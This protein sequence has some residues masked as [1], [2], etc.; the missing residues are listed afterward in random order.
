[1]DESLLQFTPPP[2]ALQVDTLH[3]G[4]KSPLVG[5]EA[6]EFELKDADGRILTGASLKGSVVLLQF[7]PYPTDDSLFRLEMAYRSLQ[8]KGLKA[9]YVLRPGRPLFGPTDRAYTVPVAF[10]S[11]GRMAKK[12]GLS[13]SGTVLIDGDGKIAYVDDLSKFSQELA[14]ALQRVGVW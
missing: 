5:T 11:E 8:S 1:V 10:D 14:E 9:I 7:S 2:G 3:F 6:P 13:Y 12:F 4:S